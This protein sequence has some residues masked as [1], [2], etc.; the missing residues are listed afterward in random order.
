MTN[1]TSDRHRCAVGK[2]QRFASFTAF[3]Q[4][5]PQEVRAAVELRDDRARVGPDS[6]ISGS[7][8]LVL[9]FAVNA[10]AALFRLLLTKPGPAPGIVGGEGREGRAARGQAHGNLA[11]TIVTQEYCATSGIQ[12]SQVNRTKNTAND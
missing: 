12:E 11:T 2:R 6:G 9:L 7:I 8:V 3:L 5:K 10:T 1:G 4:D